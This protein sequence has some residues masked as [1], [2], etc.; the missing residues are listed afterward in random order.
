MIG[1]L[2]QEVEKELGERDK[3][4]VLQK[5]SNSKLPYVESPV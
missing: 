3:S 5:L 4:G 2:P 1:T